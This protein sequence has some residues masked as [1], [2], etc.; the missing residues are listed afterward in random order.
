MIL[1]LSLKKVK[2]KVHFIGIGGIGMS[3]LARWFL[4][5]KWSVS[6][7]DK[8]L[9]ILTQ[10]LKKDGVEVKIGHKKANLKPTTALVVYSKAVSSQNPELIKAKQYGIKTMSYA[11]ALGD[12]TQHYQTI[13]VA[14]AHGKS[15]TTALL[16]LILIK[17]GFDPTVIIGTKLKEFKGKNFRAGK[18]KW[19]IIEA[20]EWQASFLN[21]SPFAAII[22]NLDR[23]HLD[24]YKN[25]SNVKKTFLKFISNIKRGGLLV[26]NR[27]D[28]NL[29]SLRQRIKKIA[30]SHKIRVCWY[31]ASK[32][33]KKFLKITGQHNL[34][35][36]SAAYKLAEKLNI[37]KEIILK[38]LSTYRGAWRR[39]EYRGKIKILNNEFLIFD[40]YAHHPTEI[41]ATLTA[42][43]EKFPHTPLF[44]VFQPHQAKRLKAL[45]KDFINAFNQA[46]VLILLPIYQVA[47]R[48]K[49][50]RQYNSQALAKKIPSSIY[51]KNPKLLPFTLK[52][53][54][55]QYSQ[56]FLF[57]PSILV[58]MGAGDIV[59]YTDDLV[60]F[61]N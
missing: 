41:K 54:I 50:D 21:Y 17:A 56:T 3:A 18:S 31:G 48:D 32:P 28:Q 59:K 25:F 46:D 60:K 19:L 40:D 2:P 52:K 58:M 26:V 49:I 42:F 39:M 5:Q 44:C 61:K 13:A 9:S 22:T 16:S 33:L 8:V 47:G 29:F 11:E 14:G 27:N 15:T 30:A 53:I 24:F 55:N 4:A 12:L 20:D 57:N 36:A 35:N 6:G 37:K 43:K 10:E 1:E 23:E 45:F 51:L 34:S 38:T 7:S